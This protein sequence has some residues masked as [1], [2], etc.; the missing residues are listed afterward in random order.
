MVLGQLTF[1]LFL[2]PQDADIEEVD[3]ILFADGKCLDDRNIKADR[4]GVRRLQTSYPSLYP[5]QKAVHDIPSLLKSSAKRF[6]N[7]AGEVFSYEKT[8]MADLRYLLIKKVQDRGVASIVW[9]EDI[10]FPFTVPRP[11]EASMRYAGILYEGKYPWLLYE[12][13]EKRKKDTKR[14]I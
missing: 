4:L 7:E 11:P 8:K 6:I 5:L 9:V 10:N 3:G 14:K 13:S 1:P 12:F 2:L